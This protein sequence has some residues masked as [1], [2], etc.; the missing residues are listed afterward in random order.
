MSAPLIEAYD[1]AL[2]DLDGVVYLGQAAVPG[3][4]DG[5]AALRRRGVRVGFVTNN[6]ARSP[7]AVVTHLEDLG[8]VATAEDVVTSAQAGA[9]LLADLVEPGALVLVVGTEALAD[10]VRAVGLAPTWSVSPLPAAVIQGYHPALPWDLI[11]KAAYAIQQGARW[12]GT[13]PDSTR[14]TDRG[15]V[16]GA[17]A[18]IGAL[19]NAVTVDP[20]IAGKP[21]TPLLQETVRRLRASSPI[22][23]GDRIDTDI[24]GAAAIGMDS[25]MV[26]TGAHG[27]RDLVAA[28]NRPTYIGWDLG[29]LLRP[30]PPVEVDGTTACC[31]GLEVRRVGQRFVV[32][33]ELADLTGQLC[34]LRALLALVE[35]GSDPDESGV[36]ELLSGLTL[37]P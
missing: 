18:Q 33:D 36:A 9:R 27:K 19:R 11:D 13:N 30:V 25:L 20:V 32:A 6:A 21:C 37:I 16:P 35:P 23:V 29:A 14:P 24:D 1:A 31:S 17:G 34:A 2:F 4:A 7:H 8:V 5:I 26:F 28:S 3:A 10:E 22:F 15:L 12:I